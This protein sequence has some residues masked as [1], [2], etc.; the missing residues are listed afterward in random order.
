MEIVL[1]PMLDEP[2]LYPALYLFTSPG[3]LLRPVW[4]LALNAQ[5]LI[6]TFEQVFKL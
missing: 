3:R 2:G 5:E 6:G 4:N 1:V